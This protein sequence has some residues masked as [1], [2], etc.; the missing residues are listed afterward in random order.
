MADFV[1]YGPWKI[2][3]TANIYQDAFIDVHCDQ[4]VRPDQKNGQHVVVAM[5]AGVCVLPIDTDQNVYLTDEFHYAIG[6]NSIEGV[7]GGI[8]PDEDAD[9]TAR[10]E[11]REELGLI[12]GDWEYL[13]TLDPFTTIV[14]SPTR[15]YFARELSQ[16]EN[17]PEGTEQIASVK[18]PLD[19]ALDQVLSGQI[20]HAP[21]CTLILIA[22]LRDG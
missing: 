1:P 5:K 15:L 7:S 16:V 21:T 12:A 13:T 3:S 17:E 19:S 11:L 18:M 8:E 22:A 4:V 9:E 10:R 20:T 2:K 6:R 14:V